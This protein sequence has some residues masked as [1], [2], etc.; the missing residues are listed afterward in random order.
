MHE[1][2]EML[3]KCIRD[4][5]PLFVQIDSDADGYTSAALFINYLNCLFPSF[6][7]NNIS[8]YLHSGK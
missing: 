8:Y 3:A 6:A 1:G 4:N 2:V 7:Q 5:K